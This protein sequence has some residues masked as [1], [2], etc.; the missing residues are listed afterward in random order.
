MEREKKLEEEQKQKEELEKFERKMKGRSRKQRKQH[1]V[2]QNETFLQK[3]KTW[4]ILS[5][6]IAVLAVFVYYVLTIVWCYWV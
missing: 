3:Y 2:I 1:E 6:S 4:I 5:A